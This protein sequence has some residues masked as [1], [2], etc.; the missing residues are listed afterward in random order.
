[1]VT[2][3]WAGILP[4]P[5]SLCEMHSSRRTLVERISSPHA[6][7]QTGKTWSFPLIS[8]A[9]KGMA[10][11][12]HLQPIQPATF[13]SVATHSRPIFPWWVPW[14]RFPSPAILRALTSLLLAR[15]ALSLRFSSFFAA[16]PN[17]G[18][19]GTVVDQ[20]QNIYLAIGSAASGSVNFLKLSPLDEP[21]LQATRSGHTFLL[22][23]PITSTG[24][25]LE[26]STTLNPGD[27]QPVSQTA[28][29]TNGAWQITLP[30]P[31]KARVFRLRKP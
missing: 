27:W 8:V 13:S 12:M 23:W 31:D 14:R 17:D 1:M 7:A 5:I 4:R 2:C 21:V 24:F 28:V 26:S 16:D 15:T 9:A 25:A 19:W 3:C 10:R 6:S 20:A 11:Y 29:S 18:V 30:M 22:S